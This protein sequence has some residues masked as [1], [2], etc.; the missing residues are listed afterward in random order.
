VALHSNGELSDTVVNSD[1]DQ[2]L[3]ETDSDGHG[4]RCSNSST[5]ESTRS[6]PRKRLRFAKTPTYLTSTGSNN[7]PSTFK[8]SKGTSVG[9][10]VSKQEE[11]VDATKHPEDSPNSLSEAQQFTLMSRAGM[12]LLLTASAALAS[13][14]SL[15]L[16]AA[17]LNL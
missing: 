13:V 6:K 1:T 5:N 9:H 11:S 14:Y 15:Y 8:S 3:F 10:N 17:K 7:N 4:Q 16:A 12:A 2:I